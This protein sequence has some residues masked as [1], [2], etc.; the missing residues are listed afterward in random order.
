MSYTEDFYSNADLD[1]GFGSEKGNRSNPHRGLDVP[2]PLG[3]PVPALQGGVVVIQEW[4][5]GLGNIVEVQQDDGRFAGYRHMRS[6]GGPWVHVGQRVEMGD[7]IGEV[8]DTGEWAEGYH[9]CHTNGSAQGAVYGSPSLV[10]DPWAWIKHYLFGAPRP[11][12]KGSAEWAFNPPIADEQAAI[13]QA[14]ANRDRYD[15][16]IDGV[17]GPNSVKGL[18]LTAR[19]VGYDGPIDGV[20]GPN[21]CYYLQV[22]A[23][24]FGDYKG[25]ID[26]VL[27][28]NSWAGVRLG[29]ER[30]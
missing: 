10:S 15:G 9:L 12:G 26:R 1:D 4:H 24:R 16:P 19:N 11:G 22:Y 29:L 27:G 8:S 13:Q 14:L 28:P 21:L 18:Q 5:D 20:E 3:A 25:P 23:Q 6:T 17:W 2:A 7:K 30:P